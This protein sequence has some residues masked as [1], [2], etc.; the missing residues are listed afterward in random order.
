MRRAD[1][2]NLEV[3]AERAVENQNTG[4]DGLP[5]VDSQS[6][7]EDAMAAIS[8]ETF[9]PGALRGVEGDDKINAGDPSQ[10]HPGQ[11]DEIDHD[12]DQIGQIGQIDQIYHDLDNL[13]PNLPLGYV[14][15]DLYGTYVPYPTQE[16]Y[17]RSCGLYRPHRAT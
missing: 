5:L 6:W 8:L 11:I 14:V 4:S 15:Q 9:F 10:F 1:K 16:A 13:D 3:V 7:E 2:N 12:I 17:P